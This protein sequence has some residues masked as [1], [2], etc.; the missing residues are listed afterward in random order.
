MEN[1][2]DRLFFGGSSYSRLWEKSAIGILSDRQGIALTDSEVVFCRDHRG[3]D[4]EDFNNP[5]SYSSW[6]SG[7]LKKNPNI[8]LIHEKPYLQQCQQQLESVNKSIFGGVWSG[9]GIGR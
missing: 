2:G 6:L 9:F 3:V 8:Q 5:E 4:F 1:M 7:R